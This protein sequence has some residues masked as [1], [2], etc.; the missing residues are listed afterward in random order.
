MLH[1][2]L[3]YEALLHNCKFAFAARRSGSLLT[4]R[5]ASESSPIGEYLVTSTNLA[6]RAILKAFFFDYSDADIEV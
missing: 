5:R 6:L 3:G 4:R 1:L 2:E